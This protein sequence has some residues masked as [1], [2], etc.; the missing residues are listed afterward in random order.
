[1]PI[2]RQDP[3]DRLHGSVVHVRTVRFAARVAGV[4]RPDA[5]CQTAGIA[6]QVDALLIE[7]GTDKSRSRSCQ[8]FLARS[9]WVRPFRLVYAMWTA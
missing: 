6:R 9:Y 1:M 8:V 5:E 7:A 4:P 2:Q 3:E